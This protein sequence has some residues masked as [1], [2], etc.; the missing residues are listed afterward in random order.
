MVTHDTEDAAAS[1][2]APDDHEE[3]SFAVVSP[4]VT[5]R[6]SPPAPWRK[7]ARWPVNLAAWPSTCESTPSI[8]V[9]VPVFID[10]G[11]HPVNAVAA[12]MLA[13]LGAGPDG[14][15]GHVAFYQT[16]GRNRS[17]A[18]SDDVRDLIQTAFDAAYA[19]VTVDADW[20]PARITCSAPAGV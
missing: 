16:D 10:H 13:L 17:V 8:G 5:W 7:Y 1:V 20:P 6:S 18:M 15:N 19:Q 9:V 14:A 4:Q 12:A 3:K 11:T 2:P